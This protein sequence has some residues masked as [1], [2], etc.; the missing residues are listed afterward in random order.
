MNTVI[1]GARLFYWLY[2]LGTLALGGVAVAYWQRE[3]IKKIFYSLAA[4]ERLIKIGMILPN[5]WIRRFYRL[6]PKGDLFKLPGGV[7]NYNIK[8]LLKNND[9]FAKSDPKDP[10]RLKVTIEGQDY[11][12]DN[13]RKL[14]QRFDR[15]PEIFYRYGNPWPLNMTQ[16]TRPTDPAPDD[17][18]EKKDLVFYDASDLGKLT[19]TNVITQL[20]ASMEGSPLM[21]LLVGLVVILII[22]VLANLGFQTGVIHAGNVTAAAHP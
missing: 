7:Y 20:L 1:L 13:A 8:D 15:W 16:E 4:P 22:L 9:A 2:L 21:G 12:I 3:R 19:K 11:F 17:S 6:I 5:G 14:K 10:T 18:A